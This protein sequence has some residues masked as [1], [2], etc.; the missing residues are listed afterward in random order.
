MKPGHKKNKMRG[1]SLTVSDYNPHHAH[2]IKKT[3]AVPEGGTELGVTEFVRIAWII[4][5]NVPPTPLHRRTHIC[6]FLI[7]EE[8]CEVESS[9]STSQSLHFIFPRSSKIGV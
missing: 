2:K 6:F 1:F 5:P 3:S 4:V 9:G 7:G 8:N